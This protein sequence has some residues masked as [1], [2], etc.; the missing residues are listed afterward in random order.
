[1]PCHG[2]LIVHIFGAS[3]MFMPMDVIVGQRVRW[4]WGLT[5]D[6]WAVFEEKNCKGKK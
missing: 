3:S 6:F 1:M 4:L 5:S 2:S